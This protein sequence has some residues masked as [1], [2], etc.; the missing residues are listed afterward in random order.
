MTDG[1]AALQDL[2]AATA[3]AV[4]DKKQAV[5]E[6]GVVRVELARLKDLALTQTTRLAAERAEVLKQVETEATA[7]RKRLKDET[8]AARGQ[9]EQETEA[10]RKALG[11]EIADLEAKKQRAEAALAG[12]REQMKAVF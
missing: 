7:E 2:A 1:R 4:E 12:L 11:A 5:A 6:Q 9:L 8:D 10:R 3:A